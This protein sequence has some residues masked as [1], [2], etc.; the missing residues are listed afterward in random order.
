VGCL[1]ALL[2]QPDQ[3]YWVIVTVFILSMVDVGATWTKSLERVVGTMLAFGMAIAMVSLF[4]QTPGLLLLVFVLVIAVALYTSLTQNVSP[5]TGYLVCVTLIIVLVP[6]WQDPSTVTT[7]GVERAQEICIGVIVTSVMVC[8]LWPASAADRLREMFAQRL[9][10]TDRR[11]AR[12]GDYLAGRE[13]GEPVKPEPQAALSTQVATLKAAMAESAMIRWAKG[14]WLGRVTVINRM[15]VQSEMLEAQVGG[16]DWSSV[17]QG[18]RGEMEDCV[19]VVRAEWKRTGEDILAEREPPVDRASFESAVASLEGQRVHGLAANRLAAVTTLLLMLRQLGRL[20]EMISWQNASA[21]T[22]LL[23]NFAVAA[24]R[25]TWHHH[26]DRV[27]LKT[28]GKALVSIVITVLLI[29]AMRWTGSMVTAVVTALLITQPTIGASWNKS[30][31]RVSGVV[32]G[33]GFG[34][35]VLVTTAAN[36]GDVWWMLIG[37]FIGSFIAG[38]LMAGDWEISY[39]GLQVGIAL[40]LV[41]GVGV[42]TESLVAP[43]GR[44]SGILVGVVVAMVVLRVL[45]PVWARRQVCES[46]ADASNTLADML[47]VGL[48]TPEE[49]ALVRP[50]NGWL[51]KVGWSLSEAYRYREEA[52]YECGIAPTRSSPVLELASLLQDA[53]PRVMLLIQARYERFLVVPLVRHAELTALREAIEDRFRA[54]AQVCLGR[55]AVIHDLHEPLAR[56]DA[57]FN[58]ATEHMDGTQR[59]THLEVIAYYQEL[60]PDLDAMVLAAEDTATLFMDHPI[61]PER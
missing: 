32:I 18:F 1:V 53:L 39:V 43:I 55:P 48:R 46:L 23:G 56:A 10:R 30:M 33:A 52:R 29:S 22:P 11:L 60:V 34:L 31:Q 13:M 51:Y 44:V 6:T 9:D 21:D 12:I 5:Y 26:F 15:A 45:W 54:V 42:P 7:L 41:L 59:T 47:E 61:G 14:K 37:L 36:S 27:A 40:G 3:A 35:V 38:W 19:D 20:S 24:R 49:E 57:V 8:I 28:T 50:P 25:R 2:F 17:P 58:L 4:P 16:A